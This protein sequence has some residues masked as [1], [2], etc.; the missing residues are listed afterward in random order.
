MRQLRPVLIS[1]VVWVAAALPLFAG[2]LKDPATLNE[3]APDI[4]RARFETTRGTFVIEVHRARAPLGAD[5][6]YNLVRNGFFT[7]VRFFRVV[8]SFVAQF[9]ISGD[10]ELSEI[11]YS[12]RI[13]DDP[14]KARNVEGSL[15]F[16][17][18]GPH[19]RT[20]QLF[21]NLK[22][23]LSLD[24]RGFAPFGQV[25]QGMDVVK[26]LYSGYGDKPRG[27][28]QGRIRAD[29]NAYLKLHFEKLDYVKS[30]AIEEPPTE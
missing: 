26:S 22:N 13:K 30:A 1:A 19:T 16:A 11:W 3:T 18:A 10:P 8:P 14:V 25:V 20:T 9:G 21:I 12:A 24:T 15:T 27:P 28:D 17:T 6:F 23:N 4:Y 2:D 5:R 29:G 7:E